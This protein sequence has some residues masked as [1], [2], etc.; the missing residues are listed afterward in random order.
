M[1]AEPCPIFTEVVNYYDN[2]RNFRA[3]QP[4]PFNVNLQHLSWEMLE[5]TRLRR[6]GIPV[7]F[8]RHCNIIYNSQVAVE[9]AANSAQQTTATPCASMSLKKTKRFSS[10]SLSPF[11]TYE[12]KTCGYFFSRDTDNRKSNFGIPAS[13]VSAW[14]HTALENLCH[15]R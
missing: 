5:A 10:N 1:E 14:R 4:L 12:K 15:L 8:S 6:L 7:R 13:D 9:N 3:V 11:F 2:P